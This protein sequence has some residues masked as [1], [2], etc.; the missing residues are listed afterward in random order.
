M[1]PSGARSIYLPT[2]S[3][4][5]KVLFP[6]KLLQPVR[7][8]KA[9]KQRKLKLSIALTKKKKTFFSSFPFK[10]SIYS[11]NSDITLS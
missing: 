5:Q 3:S 8:I 6:F 10:G 11:L 9:L 4:P 1:G 7:K 2:R